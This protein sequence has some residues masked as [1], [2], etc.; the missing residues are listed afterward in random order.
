MIC[1]GEIEFRAGKII[2]IDN[3]SGHYRPS[4]KQ[5]Q[6]CVHSLDVA[7][8]A[9]LTEL[10]GKAWYGKDWDPFNSVAQFLAKRY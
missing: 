5:L 2:W 7:D 9:D 6:N 10:K 3:A 8:N 4:A 1:A